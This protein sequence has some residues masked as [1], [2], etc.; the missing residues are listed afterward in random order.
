[1]SLN[2]Y[3]TLGRSGLRISRLAFG[4]MT[5]GKEWGWGSEKATA[6][7]IF[8]CFIDAGGNLIDTSDYYTAGT[9][10]TWLGEFVRARGVRDRVVI[11]TK[12]ANSTAPGDPNAGGNGRKHIQQAVEASLRRLGTDYIDLYQ[13]HI[14]DQITPAEEVMRCLD[15]LVRA[16]KVRY[17]GLSDIPAWYASRAQTLA[18]L[19]GWTPLVAM[20]LEYSLVERGIEQEYT[21][22]ATEMG[23]GLLSWSPLASGFLTGKY[24][25]DAAARGRLAGTKGVTNNPWYARFTER[26]LAIL[27]ELDAVAR[28]VGRSMAQVALHWVLRRPAVAGA[29]IGATTLEQLQDNLGAV[30]FVLPDELLARLDAVSTP[31]ESFPYYFFGKDFPEYQWAVH[32]ALVGDKPDGYL[33]PI[34]IENAAPPLVGAKLGGVERG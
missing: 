32:G 30:D 25:K 1:M 17:I 2:R 20:Q 24:G 28:E 11:A 33:R 27:A 7:S 4:A 9:S 16:G 6:Q 34:R 5:F 21:R 22:L 8:D 19:R 23:M 18:E 12:F 13:L 10:E 26:N 14:W 3:F 31:R 15:D 29:I